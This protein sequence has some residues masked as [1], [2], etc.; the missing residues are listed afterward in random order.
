MIDVREAVVSGNPFLELDETVSKTLRLAGTM[1][2]CDE[3]RLRSRATG[4][5]QWSCAVV[6]RGAPVSRWTAMATGGDWSDAIDGA[7]GALLA[8]VGREAVA[9][10]EHLGELVAQLQGVDCNAEAMTTRYDEL[11]ALLRELQIDV[12]DMGAR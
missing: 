2:G 12:V 7:Q 8:I 1:L 10:V 5:F 4:R 3:V 6:C 9:L 11:T